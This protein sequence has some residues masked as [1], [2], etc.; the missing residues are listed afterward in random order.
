MGLRACA[1]EGGDAVGSPFFQWLKPPRR[2]S[3]PSSWSSPSASMAAASG[4]QV[5]VLGEEG[6][7]GGGAEE[8]SSVT[9]LPLLSRLGEGKGGADDHHEQCPV[10]EEIAMSGASTD[11]AQSGVDLNIGLPVGGSGIEDVVME[12]KDDEIIG[13]LINTYLLKIL[14]GQK[15]WGG[16][17]EGQMTIDRNQL[18]GDFQL[19]ND[20]F[21]P[22]PVY[23]D[24][25]FCQRF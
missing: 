22:N 25:M 21:S 20:Y 2:S 19:F 23:P 14:Q 7:A 4:Q 6:R 1:M 5:A 3:S 15:K 11:L 12:D 24:F 13:L 10:K 16:S 8:A 18:Q 17:I 9:C